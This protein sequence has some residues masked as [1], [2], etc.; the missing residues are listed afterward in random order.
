VITTRDGDLEFDETLLTEALD[1]YRAGVAGFFTDDAGFGQ[2]LLTALDGYLDG[3]GIVDA[4]LDGL[5]SRVDDLQDQ[6]ARWEDR[7]IDIEA[8]YRAQFTALDSLVSE[9]LA[10]SNFLTQQL[11]GLPGVNNDS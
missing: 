11:A 4:R 7:L 2:G 6:Q 1:D 5:R 8:R 9:L 10:T 3:N